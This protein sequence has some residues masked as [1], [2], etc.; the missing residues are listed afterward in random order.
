MAANAFHQMLTEHLPRL[1]AYAIMLTRDRVAAEDLLQET[2]LRALRAQSQFTLGTNFTAW[3]YRILR[4]EYISSL[5]RSKRRPI[6]LED[7]PEELLSR[8]GEQ[9]DKVLT[10]EIIHAMD[11]LQTSQREVLILICAGGLSYEE[12]AE[13]LECSVGTIKSRLWRARRHMQALVLGK[14]LE[15]IEAPA[16]RASQTTVAADGARAP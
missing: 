11:K 2:A 3:M 16:E 8:G 10:N 15:E 13:S 9:D 1:R 14:E 7:I 6:L 4:N 5:R 12:A